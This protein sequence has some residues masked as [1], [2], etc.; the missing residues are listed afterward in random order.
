MTPVLSLLVE[1]EKIETNLKTEM[2]FPF[3]L[4]TWSTAFEEIQLWKSE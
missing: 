4:P 1:T 3:Q 2:L